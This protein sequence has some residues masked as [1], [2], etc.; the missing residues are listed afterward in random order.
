MVWYTLLVSE[1]EAS[2]RDGEEHRKIDAK[3]IYNRA[4]GR[5]ER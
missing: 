2:T 5:L 4:L 3:Y 1:I